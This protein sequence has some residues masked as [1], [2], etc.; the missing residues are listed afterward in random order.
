MIGPDYTDVEFVS[1]FH[2]CSICEKQYLCEEENCDETDDTAIC[3]DCLE[4]DD[5]VEEDDADYDS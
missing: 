3:E 4:Y 1:H 5:G 2:I